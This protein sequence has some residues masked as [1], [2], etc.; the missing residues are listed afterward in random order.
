M[1]KNLGKVVE[2]RTS[3]SNLRPMSV[4]SSLRLLYTVLHH[5]DNDYYK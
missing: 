4:E 5:A 3:S 2:F 1:N